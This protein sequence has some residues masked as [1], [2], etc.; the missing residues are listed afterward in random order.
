ML[1]RLPIYALFIGS[2][3]IVI[4][5]VMFLRGDFRHPKPAPEKAEQTVRISGMKPVAANSLISIVTTQ[6]EVP[7]GSFIQPNMLVRT[8]I[9][10]SAVSQGDIIWSPS[11]INPLIG[12]M[13]RKT[14]AAGTHVSR[15]MIIEP[16]DHGFLSAVL[17]PGQEAVTIQVNEVM[18]SSGLVWP[19][20][21]VAIVLVHH[22]AKGTSGSDTNIS[23]VTVVPSARVVATGGQLFHAV[24]T[25]K[26]ASQT[27]PT[28]TL[29]VKPREAELIVLAAKLGSL[30][31]LPLSAKRPPVAASPAWGFQITDIA[32]T[33]SKTRNIDIISATGRRRVSVP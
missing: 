15:S 18:D 2:I 33:E 22:A 9:P 25:S 10:A 8:A 29:G 7:A 11:N 13:A 28:V 26:T 27:A 23:A 1:R 24:A 17:K 12:G 6:K 4:A 3:A 32:K 16:G 21:H 30:S 20:D 14:L 31:I 19:G 5:V